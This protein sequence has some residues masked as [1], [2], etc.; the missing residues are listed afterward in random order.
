MTSLAFSNQAPH[1]SQYDAARTEPAGTPGRRARIAGRIVSGLGVAFL[2]FDASL[3]LL[4]LD[5]AVK[6]TV[7]LGYPAHQVFALGLLQLAL[8]ITYLIP[9]TA[10]LGAVLW[11]GYFGGAIATHVRLEN[12][13][14]SHVLFPIY[15]A[16]L[17]WVGLWLR[18]TRVRALIRA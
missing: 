5:W 14:F 16:A 11:T 6:G 10:V 17:L 18:D 3:K 4:V 13:L 1:T 8:M 7:E 9:R 12:P 15:I 2:T